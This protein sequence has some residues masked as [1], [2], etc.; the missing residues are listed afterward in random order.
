VPGIVY[1]HGGPTGQFSDTYALQPQFLARMGYAVIMPN[2]RGSSGYGKVF[3]D[4]NNPCWTR[5][6]LKDVVAAADYLKALPYVNPNA[7]GITGIS[8]GGIMSMAA[9]ARAPDVF[10]ASMP[11]SGYANWISF[12]DYNAELQHTKLLAYEWGPYPDSAAVYRRNSSIFEIQN[13]K[14]PVFLVH[15][16]GRETSWRPGVPPIIASQEY[17]LALEKQFKVVKY[18]TYPGETYYISRK[19]NNRQLLMDM[20]DFFDQYLKTGIAAPAP[21]AAMGRE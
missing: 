13:V 9:V 14:A 6:D 10:Q 2:I 19:D 11:Q 17:A 4:A 12:Q 20:L 18:K 5:C 15:G 8:Y 1:V 7:I 16:V 21:A 3:E